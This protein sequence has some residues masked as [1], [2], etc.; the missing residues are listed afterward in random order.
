MNKH[1]FPQIHFYDQDFVD[2]YNKTWSW[3]SSFWI[4]PSNGEQSN[5]GLF[6]YPENG[7]MILNQF[8][9]IFSSFF[10]VYSN[11]NFDACNN[12]DYFYARQ[13]DNGAIRNR[14]DV[15]TNEPV[16]DKKN[17][18]GLDLPLFAWAEFN[19]YHKSA[20]KRRIKEVMP[21]LIKYMNWIDSNFKKDN[22][23]YAVPAAA[24]GM[25]NSPRKDSVYPVDFNACMAINASYMSALGDILNDKD[26]SFQYRKMYFS[27]KTRINSL[28]WDPKTN[29]YYDL[30]KAQERIKTK[31]IAAF[32]TMLAE[33]PNA[34]K[35][36]ALVDHLNN[37][38]SFGTEHPFPTLSADDP[39]FSEDGNGYCGSVFPAFN[40]MVI[41]GLEKYGKYE[42]ARECAIRH[43]Y[44][45]LDGLMPNESSKQAGD[46]WEAYLPN[47]EGKA[48]QRGK[49]G[50]PRKRYLLT[51]GLST[52]AL[53]IENIIGLSISLPRK[54]VDWIIPN[55]EIMGIEKLSLKRNL[56]TILSNKSD[57]GWGI[58]M[59][60]EKLYYFTI[61]IKRSFPYEQIFFSFG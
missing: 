61:N 26:L 41:K 20:N 47:K 31:T 16:L 3:V 46:L 6:I 35:A 37:P 45:V 28:M 43:L 1:D 4:N 14:Y 38:K 22:G 51:A 10:L 52:I 49:P 11:R 25:I 24:S 59:E 2:I 7:K 60:S 36:D 48:V 15:S 18:Q 29:F 33:I 58:Q 56:I 42:L 12:L 32:W 40:F 53:M 39:N 5:D 9:S 57:R 13:E 50:F 30:N 55:L 21:T 19:L 34:D 23:L 17:P 27:I 8:E 54:T 44:Y